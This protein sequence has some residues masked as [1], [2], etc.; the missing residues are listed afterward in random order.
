MDNQPDHFWGLRLF[1]ALLLIAGI[2][3][4]GVLAY[5]AGITQG[6]TAA[7]V[8]VE[9]VPHGGAIWGSPFH[10]LFAAPFLLCLVPLF[11]CMFVFMPL[12]LA[13]GPRRHMHM[14]H[15][16]HWDDGEVPPPIAE[17]H[18]R[19]HETKPEPPEK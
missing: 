19:M 18:R 11:L 5:N 16:W 17:M 1:G 6:Q 4:I 12:R 2:V 9:T 14:R 13:F 10:W 15:H 8:Q 7:P 3:A